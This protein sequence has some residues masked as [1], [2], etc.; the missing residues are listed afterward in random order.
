M[1]VTEVAAT[2]ERC[3][4]EE[5]KFGPIVW[6]ELQFNFEQPGGYWC[7]NIKIMPD[8][9]PN[10]IAAKLVNLAGLIKNRPLNETQRAVDDRLL[11][12]PKK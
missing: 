7:A 5:F 11:K 6:W 3:V 2:A 12:G 10:T 8:D 1:R 4:N 9:D